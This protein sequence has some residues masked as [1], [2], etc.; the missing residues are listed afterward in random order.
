MIEL[1]TPVGVLDIGS[2]TSKFIIFS[3]SSSENK[4]Q[5]LANTIINT[6]GVKKGIISDLDN[7][8]ETVKKLIGLAEDKSQTQ[9]SKIYISINPLNLSF[10][11]FCQSKYIGD[12]E[13]DET[14]DVQFLVNSGINLFKSSYEEKKIIH[15]FNYNLRLDKINLVDNP[16]GLNADSLENDMSIICCNKNIFKNYQKLIKKSY[17]NSEN[18]IS[19]SYSLACSIYYENLLAD[20]FLIID[21]GH[22]KTSLSIFKNGNFIYSSSIAI[23]SW[24]VTNDIS[25][26]LNLNYEIAEKLKKDYASCIPENFKDD[27]NFLDIDNDQVKSFKKVSNN[28]LNKITNSRVEEIID[29]INKEIS[30][31]NLGNVTFNKIIFTGKGSYLKSFQELLKRKTKIKTLVF[32]KLSLKLKSENNFTDDYDVCLSIITLLQNRYKSEITMQKKP[33]NSFFDKFYS[34]FK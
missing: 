1:D 28:I 33:K 14:N 23:G 6:K 27:R 20:I 19:S 11:S 10:I 24:H 26:C 18:F 17:I 8:S 25:K 31:L 4:I 12:S 32:E 30:S 22:E 16:C 34:I 2:E 5:I 3:I 15:V 7:L 9:I 13:I 29:L 21:F